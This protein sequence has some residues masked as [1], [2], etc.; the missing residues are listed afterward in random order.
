M[1]LAVEPKIFF[2]DRGGVGIEN[3]YLVTDTG[4]EKLTPYSDEIIIIQGI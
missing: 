3:M 2:P 1:V 4:C